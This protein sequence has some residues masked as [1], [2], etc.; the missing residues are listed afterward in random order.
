MDLKVMGRRRVSCTEP[1]VIYA[2]I[3]FP[4]NFKQIRACLFSDLAC[5]CSRFRPDAHHHDIS[6]G[7]EPE[8]TPPLQW[9]HDDA[10][11]RPVPPP[12]LHAVQPFE[13]NTRAACSPSACQSGD[14]EYPNGFEGAHFTASMAMVWGPSHSHC[15]AQC[16]PT[17]RFRL[18]L[19]PPVLLSWCSRAVDISSANWHRN[20][21]RPN[22]VSELL[23]QCIH[24][25]AP[26]STWGLWLVK[27][28][29]SGSLKCAR[30]WLRQV[31]YIL[32]SVQTWKGE[33]S[34]SQTQAQFL[35]GNSSRL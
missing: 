19:P 21:Q 6:K 18:T 16:D 3:G 28:F 24:P 9:H 22:T 25:I 2:C 33:Y 35:D 13:V 12:W 30:D 10:K 1:F 11:G 34:Q 27:Q 5:S 14:D 23:I 20:G 32:T 31:S 8:L 29:K 4:W 26:V 15:E 17:G 7:A